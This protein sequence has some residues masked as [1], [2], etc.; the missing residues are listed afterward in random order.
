MMIEMMMIII[1]IYLQNMVTSGVLNAWP[2]QNVGSRNC[3]YNDCQK[4]EKR[5]VTLPEIVGN[6]LVNSGVPYRNS[7]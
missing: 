5:V 2:L 3:Q 6:E 7:N 1:I 4:F